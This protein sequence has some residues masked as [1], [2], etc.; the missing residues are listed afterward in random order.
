MVHFRLIVYLQ[1]KI[2]LVLIST[3]TQLQAIL[4]RIE[5]FQAP[6]HIS[7]SDAA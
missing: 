4:S 1:I 7:Q 6:F 3:R 5:Q 2:G